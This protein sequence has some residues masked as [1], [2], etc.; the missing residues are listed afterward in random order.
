[1]IGTTTKNSSAQNERYLNDI[2]PAIFLLT[3]RMCPELQQIA[4]CDYSF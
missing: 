4:L 3:P 2:S 1:M